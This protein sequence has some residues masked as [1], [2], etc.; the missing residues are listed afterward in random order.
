[1]FGQRFYMI[2]ILERCTTN[3]IR[4]NFN[5]YK[6]E[7]KN[8]LIKLNS[9][10]L[11]TLLF[12]LE[13]LSCCCDLFFFLCRIRY[14]AILF[15]SY[16]ICTLSIRKPMCSFRISW[17]NRKTPIFFW[18]NFT[19][20][21]LLWWMPWWTTETIDTNLIWFSFLFLFGSIYV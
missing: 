15:F 8:I 14:C 7:K 18:Y 5:G 1:M 20:T 13:I 17:V 16:G 12:I 6:R 4:R 9:K 10:S 21:L 3:R 19:S 2:E 11:H